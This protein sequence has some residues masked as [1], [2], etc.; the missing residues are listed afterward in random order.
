MKQTFLTSPFWDPSC[1]HF[2][3]FFCSSVVFVFMFY[4][5]AFMFVCWPCFWYILFSS[6]FVFVLLLVWLSDY[7]NTVFPA[8]FLFNFMCLFL[9][10]FLCCLFPLLTIS[11]YYFV[12]VL[13]GFLFYLCNRTKW[14]CCLHLVVLFPFCCDGL[15]F[16]FLS[17]IS[18][19][20]PK[21]GH[22]NKEC[23]KNGQLLSVS[24]VVFTN[25][26]PNLGGG[27]KMQILLNTH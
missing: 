9:F 4:V 26:V 12:S 10:G 18:K 3:L 24:A 14:F 15:N 17:F 6:C 7:G 1:L 22:N 20:R 23:R 5:S 16:V 19:K 11:L 8:T 13:S 2:L 21:N 25:S 27:L